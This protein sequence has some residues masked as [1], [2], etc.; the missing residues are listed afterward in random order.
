MLRKAFRLPGSPR[1]EGGHFKQNR[2]ARFRLAVDSA[3]M[4][5]QETR[6][7]GIAF[8]RAILEQH[9]ASRRHSAHCALLPAIQGEKIRG[10][11][12]LGFPA[13]D[14][15]GEKLDRGAQPARTR[16]E[17]MQRSASRFSACSGLS[18]HRLDADATRFFAP[19]RDGLAG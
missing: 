2:G 9:P 8:R 12:F 19:L 18:R 13:V 15:S 1:K 10:G 3:S 5:G 16:P 14:D 17:A 7:S 6:D 11:R 4:V